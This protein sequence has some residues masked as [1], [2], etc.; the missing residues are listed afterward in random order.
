M[1]AARAWPLMAFWA[2][3]LGLIF[4]L[5]SQ[6]KAPQTGAGQPFPPLSLKALKGHGAFDAAAMQGRVTLVNFF[7]SW[8]APCAA[9]M[10]EL[11]KLRRLQPAVRFVG[12]AWNDVPKTLNPWLVQHHSPFQE[13]WLDAAGASTGPL[14]IQGIP[15]TFI[16]DKTGHIRYQLAGPVTPK[17][18]E[19]VI[20]PLV[21]DLLNETPKTSK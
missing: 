21:K 3:V 5:M 18:A 12:I 7:A 17:L 15:E 20:T 9:E 2:L 6:P 10:P 4:L 8:C 1:S 13:V 11:A 19:E 16:V 14:G